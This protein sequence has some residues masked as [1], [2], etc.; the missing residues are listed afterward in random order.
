M[1]VQQS[2]IDWKAIVLMRKSV[3]AQ[4]RNI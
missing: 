3:M 1:I 2:T 4:R